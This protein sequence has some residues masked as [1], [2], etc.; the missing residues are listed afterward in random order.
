MASFGPQLLPDGGTLLF[1]IVKRT[2]AAIDRWDDAQIV[3]Q[4]LETGVR[5][6][7]IEGG[8]DARYV[9]TGHIV[10]VSGGTLFAVPFDLPKLE[11]T[12][13][14]VPVVEGVRRENFSNRVGPV[15]VFQLGFAGLCARPG[16]GRAGPGAVRSQGRRGAAQASAGEVPLPARVSRWQADRV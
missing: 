3:V 16:V 9:P 8:S 2:T 7:L 13:G 5:K 6:P 11:V 4:S 14:A 1:T 15:R 12:G 10:Y